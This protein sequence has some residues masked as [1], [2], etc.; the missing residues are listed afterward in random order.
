MSY[1]LM[2]QLFLQL[3]GSHALIKSLIS[4]FLFLLQGM[5]A[6]FVT[7]RQLGITLSEAW[8]YQQLKSVSLIDLTNCTA[9]AETMRSESG[10]LCS[11]AN[12]ARSNY[13][14]L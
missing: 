12:K 9:S 11:R 6:N 5:M 14:P 2:R 13:S 7:Y 8:G 4:N 10:P 3:L 1:L